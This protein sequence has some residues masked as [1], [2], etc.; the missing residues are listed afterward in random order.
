VSA[1]PAV[2]GRRPDAE[3]VAVAL[4]AGLIALAFAAEPLGMWGGNVHQWLP[5]M[6]AHFD[7]ELHGW[8]LLPLVVAV[9]TVA[10]GQ[11]LAARLPWRGV[12]GLTWVVGVLWGFGLALGR[13]WQEGIVAPLADQD[14]YLVDVPRA[15][16]MGVAEVLRDY[17]DYILLAVDDHWATHNS[18]H[19]PL[20]LLFYT[21]LDRIGLG[22]SQAS[23]LVTAATGSTAVVAVLVTIRVLGDERRARTAAPFLALSPLVIWI[24]ISADGAFAA[25]VAGG[26]AVL[27]LAAVSPRPGRAFAL[28]VAAG[29]L[30]G[31]G[32]FLSYGLVLMSPIAVAVLIAARQWRPLLP[33]ALAAL[34]VVGA[35]ALVGFWW[36]EAQQILVTRYYEGKGADRPFSYWVWGN[37]AV[38]AI[39]LGPA[40]WA[41]G[42]AAARQVRR[43][44]WAALRGRSGALWLVAGAAV[45]VLSADLSM[46]SK[47][48]VERIWLPFMV[49]LVPL[50]AQLRVDERRRWLALQAA[51]A[52]AVCVVFRTTW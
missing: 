19:P 2:R 45:A 41:A 9:T 11:R 24:W 44:P 43:A 46:L 35:F 5:P 8:L 7:P 31:I 27:A 25:V 4:V 26:I 16:D 12:L 14:E 21:G 15:S 22:G 48:E 34:A 51:W 50:T 13:G 6:S 18:G 39:A 32:L 52:L 33:A 37:L 3:W 28:A 40:V 49:W 47:S 20:P 36:Y 42:G 10:Y 38:A 30:L 17:T 29:L 1:R 23:G